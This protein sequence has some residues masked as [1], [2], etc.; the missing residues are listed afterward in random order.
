MLT[1]SR[2]ILYS[3]DVEELKNFYQ[4]HFGFLLV[5]EIKDEWIVLKAGQIQLALHRV[6]KEYEGF[7]STYVAQSNAKMVFT[8]NSDI[9]QF[10]DKLI[11]GKVSMRK[12]RS[13]SGFN[14]LLCDG[15]D[16]E[17]N[18]FQLMQFEK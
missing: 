18:V 17:G 7:N 6:G 12:V 14:Y 11:A 8:I 9:H 15:T 13:Y 16:P 4:Q 2:L 3:K 10:R 5:E 1:F